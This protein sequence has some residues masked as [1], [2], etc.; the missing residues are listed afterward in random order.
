MISKAKAM[1]LARRLP[2]P[3]KP[4]EVLR[5]MRVEVACAWMELHG[6]DPARNAL[7]KPR[8][9]FGVLVLKC[10]IEPAP[11]TPP[12]APLHLFEMERGVLEEG[13]A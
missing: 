5:G 6:L 9:E 3:P 13:D 7:G 2:G 8:W 10:G 11:P 1:E 4:G 12:P